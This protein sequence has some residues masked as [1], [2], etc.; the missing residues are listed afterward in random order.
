MRRFVLLLVLALL[1]AL[2]AGNWI[3]TDPG[4]LY[5]SRSDWELETTLGF[6]AV[7]QVLLLITLTSVL[8]ILASAWNLL[9]PKRA[10][11]RWRRFLA[12]RRLKSG[13]NALLEG[14]WKKAGRQLASSAKQGDW[15]LPALLGAAVAAHLDGDRS[16]S[17]H[18]LMQASAEPGGKLPAGLLTAHIAMTEG[19]L[20]HAGRVLETLRADHESNPLLLRQLADLYERTERWQALV[21]LMPALRKANEARVAPELREKRAWLGLFRAAATHNKSADSEA[22]AAVQQLWHS[23]PRRLRTEPQLR[24]AYARALAQFGHG[25]GAVAL[26]K[27]DLKRHWD[28]RYP[29]ILEA[30]EDMAPDKLLALTEGWLEQQPGSLPLLVTSGRLALKARLWGK[31]RFFFEKAAA[32][33]STVALAELA[34]LYMALGEKG[35]AQDCVQRQMALQGTTLPVLPLPTG[36]AKLP[37]ELGS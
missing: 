14:Q 24:L 5:L 27:S 30:V 9:A 6:A 33:N 15:P 25:K 10:A 37:P 29:P 8:L 12:N 4:Y 16:A 17:Q 23:M 32:Q 2:V 26:V 7:V 21:D 19:A 28:D 3:L 1:A 11:G 35:K 20:V 36:A 34:R 18:H 31:A 22:L 13:L